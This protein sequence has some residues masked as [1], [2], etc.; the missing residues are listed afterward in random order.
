MTMTYSG[1]LYSTNS[2]QSQY[3]PSHRTASLTSVA[4]TLSEVKNELLKD[5]MDEFE[6]GIINQSLAKNRGNMAK[7]AR[8]LGVTERIIG[9]RVKKYSIDCSQF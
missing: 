5:Q 8:E 2:L 1:Q 9:L 3:V 7:T 6:L 4:P